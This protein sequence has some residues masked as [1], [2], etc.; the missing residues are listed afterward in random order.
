M[1]RFRFVLIGLQI[2]LMFSVTTAYSDSC[3]MNS[4]SKCT[5]LKE[6]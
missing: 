3:T 2:L 4:S 5:T 1:R 6:G